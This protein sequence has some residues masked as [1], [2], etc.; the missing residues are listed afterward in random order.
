M[1]RWRKVERRIPSTSARFLLGL[2]FDFEDGDDMGLRNAGLSPNYTA[3]RHKEHSLQ[4]GQ[5]TSTS[6]LKAPADHAAHVL[7]THP[8]RTPYE[9][10]MKAASRFFSFR[11]L[12]GLSFIR[13]AK[14]ELS[15]RPLPTCQGCC[16]RLRYRAALKE[17]RGNAVAWMLRRYATSR[18]AEGRGILSR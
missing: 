13:N 11:L 9:H 2:F 17:C 3:L 8:R 15:E 1:T 18:K 10:G 6:V 14:E 4:P 7:T 12:N 5:S 16:V